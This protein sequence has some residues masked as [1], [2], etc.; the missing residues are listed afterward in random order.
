MP[1]RAAV[2]PPLGVRQARRGGIEPAVH[3]AVVG[4]HRAAIGGGDH[5][6]APRIAAVIASAAKQS[7]AKLKLA[8]RDCFVAARLAMTTKRFR[9]PQA[10][11]S[12]KLDSD[13]HEGRDDAGRKARAAAADAR[14]AAFLGRDAGRRAA[15]AAL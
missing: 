3:L 15:P 11:P 4:G 9:L 2:A 10:A 13:Q 5:G 1:E 6:A 14:D 8:R 7:R 12:V